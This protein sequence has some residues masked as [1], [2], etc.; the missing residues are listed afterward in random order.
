MKIAS[1]D[2]EIAKEIPEDET[3]WDKYWPLG[4]SC[5][6]IAHSTNPTEDITV[7]YF[8]GKPQASVAKCR[9]LSFRLVDLMADGYSLVTVNGTGFDFKVLS[10]ES[11]YADTCA[12]MAL[13]H[14]DLMLS[15]TFR[16][17]HYLG[18]DSMLLGAGLKTKSHTVTLSDGT[19]IDDMTGALAPYYWNIGEYGAVLEYLQ[20]DVV[21]P[22][23]LAHRIAELG[24]INW[25]SNAG[26]RRFVRVN[27]LETVNDL[28]EIPEPDTSWMGET[29][30]R[31]TQFFEW[32]P[33]YINPL[34]QEKSHA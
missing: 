6:A 10:E 22:L 11:G 26:K 18:L 8:Y 12:R 9:Q 28:F 23:K 34:S 2:L 20:G 29:R 16:K 33:E 19:Q 31:R 5:A 13:A 25:T 7:E 21:Q 3:D 15:V 4:I 17:G 30:P 32:M 24:V 1:F 14:T 27:G